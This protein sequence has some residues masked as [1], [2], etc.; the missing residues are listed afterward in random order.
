MAVRIPSISTILLLF[1][2][3]SGFTKLYISL[4][5]P[6]GVSW[7][8]VMND[9]TTDIN[10]RHFKQLSFKASVLVVWFF[11]LNLAREKTIMR[12]GGMKN[13]WLIK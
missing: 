3:N 1:A 5:F 2:D 7:I 8:L 4:E 9:F 13:D 6:V 12:I 10:R 11:L